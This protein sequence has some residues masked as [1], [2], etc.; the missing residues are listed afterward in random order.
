M[1]LRVVLLRVN[2][3]DAGLATVRTVHMDFVSVHVLVLLS[4]LKYTAICLRH[5]YTHAVEKNSGKIGR[6]LHQVALSRDVVIHC[7][8]FQPAFN[9]V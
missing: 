2:K 9:Q 1:A 6:I 4:A 7:W 8:R 3:V 5:L